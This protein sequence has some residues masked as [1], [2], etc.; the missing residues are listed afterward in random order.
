MM[1]RV[2]LACRTTAIIIHIST[3]LSRL[4]QPHIRMF[5]FLELPIELRFN[6]Y[7]LVAVPVKNQPSDYPGLYL[8]C[9]QIKS[10]IDQ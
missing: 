1:S 5:P 2:G 9:S 6:I 4:T 7:A 3:H 8:S 10:E